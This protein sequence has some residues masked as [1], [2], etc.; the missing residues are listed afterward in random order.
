MALDRGNP[1]EALKDRIANLVRT[2][3]VIS[4]PTAIVV[5]H[6]RHFF[7]ASP[8]RQ[9]LAPTDS[10]S[11]SYAA[12]QESTD[13]VP[14]ATAAR[15]RGSPEPDV[16]QRDEATRTNLEPRT[17]TPIPA[18]DVS[19]QPVCTTTTAA[20]TAS[21]EPGERCIAKA[22]GGGRDGA[23]CRDRP[24]A[25][26]SRCRRHLYL[27]DMSLPA[28]HCAGTTAAGK[29][30][31]FRPAIDCRFCSDHDFSCNAGRGAGAHIAPRHPDAPD[32]PLKIAARP[33]P[34]CVAPAVCKPPADPKLHA[35]ILA[36]ATAP[37][38]EQTADLPPRS[39]PA[40]LSSFPLPADAVPA[41]GALTGGPTRRRTRKPGLL[42]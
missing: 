6:N 18:A 4:K 3:A 30:C 42:A 13:L 20:A 24:L 10:V 2:H 16:Q 17:A 7:S 9:R 23:R 27:S 5:F 11:Q 33:I 41:R 19:P 34:F 22:T 8:P 15:H 1:S 37:D 31:C 32:L 28:K 38:P 36:A 12:S 29:P 14:L 21:E 26:F 35:A 40:A 25:G 39:P